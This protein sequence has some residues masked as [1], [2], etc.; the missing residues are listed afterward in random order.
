M[1]T[2]INTTKAAW[3]V[4]KG[5]DNQTRFVR[6]KFIGITIDAELAPQKPNQRIHTL[7]KK[8][9]HLLFGDKD[10]APMVV[11][12]IGSRNTNV[13][14]VTEAIAMG[15]RV[16]GI[17]VDGGYLLDRNFDKEEFSLIVSSRPSGTTT[18]EVTVQLKAGGI[19][20]YTYVMTENGDI[21]SSTKDVTGVNVNQLRAPR[22]YKPFIITKAILVHRSLEQEARAKYGDRYTYVTFSNLRSA[23]ATA[24]KLVADGYKVVT[25]YKS[26]NV[27]AGTTKE[28]YDSSIAYFANTL[29]TRFQF[30]HL[31][32]SDGKIDRVIN[33]DK[34]RLPKTLAEKAR[35][36]KRAQKNH[37]KK[38]MT[39]KRT[40]RPTTGRPA[41]SYQSK[42]KA[43]AGANSRVAVTN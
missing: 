24:D 2:L 3:K 13:L 1:I 8:K 22:P 12:S 33:R 38:I 26:A 21:K 25:L 34:P 41:T 20:R 36:K 4:E 7:H 5:A 15:D 9:T 6:N 23:I 28:E 32:N 10:L 40:P 18:L 29:A 16:V 30:V 17:H 43:Y 35:N 39:K 27:A 14:I 42:N 37:T 11:K 31:L 19:Q